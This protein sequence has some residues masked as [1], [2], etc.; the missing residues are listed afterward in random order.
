MFLTQSQLYLSPA[1]T[2]LFTTVGSTTDH[3]IV[4]VRYSYGN[5]RQLFFWDSPFWNFFNGR[6][7]KQ[8]RECA[9]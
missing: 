3:G 5:H 4:R 1:N 6:L 9:A 8:Y 2:F 7:Y